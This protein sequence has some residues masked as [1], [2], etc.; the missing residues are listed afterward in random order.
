MRKP[1]VKIP[2]LNPDQFK[3]LGDAIPKNPCYPCAGECEND[4]GGY[5]AFPADKLYFHGPTDDTY[6][7]GFYCEYCLDEILDN[8]GERWEELT[9]FPLTD[10]MRIYDRAGQRAFVKLIRNRYENHVSRAFKTCRNRLG[11]VLNGC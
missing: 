5:N 11:K 9:K 7:S 3:A 4:A 2:K 10:A 1:L 8:T 6:P